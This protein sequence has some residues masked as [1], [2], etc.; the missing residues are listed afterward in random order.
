MP[1]PQ[2]TWQGTQGFKT[3]AAARVAQRAMAAQTDPTRP[4]LRWVIRN[5]AK[6]PNRDGS[7]HHWVATHYSYRE[8]D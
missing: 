8:G 5:I 3:R 2:L 4:G 7:G 1:T 6:V